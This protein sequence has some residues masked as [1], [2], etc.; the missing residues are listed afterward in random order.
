MKP[1]TYSAAL[2]AGV[3]AV[4]VFVLVLSVWIMIKKGLIKRTAIEVRWTEEKGGR[5]FFKIMSSGKPL[6]AEVTLV[7]RDGVENVRSSE[8][9]VKNPGDLERA[10]FF[11]PAGTIAPANP[12]KIVGLRGSSNMALYVSAQYASVLD[13]YDVP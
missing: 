6:E 9:S 7:Y 10:T 5:N 3:L 4:G 8:S 2:V 11:I 12:T 1:R 13:W